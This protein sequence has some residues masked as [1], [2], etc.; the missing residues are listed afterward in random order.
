M[1][2]L[3]IVFVKASFAEYVQRMPLPDSQESATP[4]WET[5][6]DPFSNSDDGDSDDDSEC[7]SDCGDCGDDVPDLVDCYD[8]DD[9]DDA[10]DCHDD[11]SSNA[12]QEGT[13]PSTE[14][15]I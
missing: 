14:V 5:G 3:L 10:D 8:F 15:Y 2:R 12:S 11:A 1:N 4:S 9:A 13:Q 6:A 7:L